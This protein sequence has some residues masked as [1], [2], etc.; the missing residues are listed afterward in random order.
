[1]YCVYKYK[2][3]MI[4]KDL[5]GAGYIFGDVLF[6]LTDL[7]CWKIYGSDLGTEMSNGHGGPVTQIIPNF[8]SHGG[9]MK[10]NWK[11]SYTTP[12]NLKHTHFE[13]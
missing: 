10:S 11:F 12:I 5:R 1:M 8:N 7:G 4:G 9:N 6:D 2:K 13:K 3:L